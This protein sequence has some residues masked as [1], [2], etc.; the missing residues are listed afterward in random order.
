[1]Y[2]A[3]AIRNIEAKQIMEGIIGGNPLPTIK[4][5]TIAHHNQR[6]SA[7]FLDL[8]RSTAELKNDLLFIL[9]ALS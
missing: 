2:T 5:A 9:R 7:S 8:I 6:P 3:V 1:M 4:A